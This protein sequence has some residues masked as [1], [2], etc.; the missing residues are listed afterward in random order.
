VLF[1][2]REP[3]VSAERRRRALQMIESWLVRRMIMGWT[4]KSYNQQIPVIIGRVAEAPERA[5]EIVLDEL[6]TGV[7]LISRWP[8]DDEVRGVLSTATCMATSHRPGS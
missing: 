2:F 8:T 4:A 6:R 3:A 7:G 1:L 5:D